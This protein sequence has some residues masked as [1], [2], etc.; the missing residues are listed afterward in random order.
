MKV[1]PL[2]V[3]EYPSLF[4][5]FTTHLGVYAWP[6]GSDQL[7][8]RTDRVQ[9][10]DRLSV[11]VRAAESVVLPSDTTA[12]FRVLEFDEVPAWDWP[13][14]FEGQ[15]TQ[16]AEV[17]IP[18][19]GSDRTGIYDFSFSRRVI[20][21]LKYL[22][23]TLRTDPDDGPPNSPASPPAFYNAVLSGRIRSRRK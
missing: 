4:T 18:D 22:G 23:V 1:R 19:N 15:G 3:S 20:E 2:P 6:Y 11:L 8:W 21:P 9:I 7:F 13:T 5:S 10:L 14:G 16:I 12:I 17:E